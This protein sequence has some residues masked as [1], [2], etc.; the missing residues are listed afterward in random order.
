MTSPTT[1]ARLLERRAGIEPQLPHGEQQPPMHGL[2]PIARVRQRTVHDGG[3]RIGEIALFERLAQC[4]LLDV[5]RFGRNQPLAHGGSVQR[6]RGANKS[7]KPRLQGRDAVEA[8][9]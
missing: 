9:L 3:Q 4:D 7:T 2:E 8:I 1:R 5:G 6:R